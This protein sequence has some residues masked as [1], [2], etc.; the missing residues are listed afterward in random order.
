MSLFG[1]RHGER[2]DELE[3][4][5]QH[6][7]TIHNV[8]AQEVADVVLD[9]DD[10]DDELDDQPRKRRVGLWITLGVVGVVFGFGIVALMKVANMADQAGPSAVSGIQEMNAS[11]APSPKANPTMHGVHISF[12]YPAV[13]DDVSQLG[14]WSN[15]SERYQLVAKSD[16]RKTIQVYVENGVL[17]MESGYMYRSQHPDIYKPNA[18]KVMGEPAV[19]MVKSDNSERTLYWQHAG[20]MVVMSAL[21]EGNDLQGYLDVIIASL[22][23]VK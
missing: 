4:Q 1:N 12:T 18:V 16:Y 17:N 20:K 22:R 5:V 9:R 14:N 6:L 19:I 2:I 13:F 8:S 11:I 3:R 21:G 15:T 7:A 10:E 23:W